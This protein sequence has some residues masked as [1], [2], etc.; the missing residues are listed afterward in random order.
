MGCENFIFV[1]FAICVSHSEVQK[2]S[3]VDQISANTKFILNP[4]QKRCMG[5]SFW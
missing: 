4:L 5:R 2:N 3:K 1:D